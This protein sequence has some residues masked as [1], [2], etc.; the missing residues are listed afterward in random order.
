MNSRHIGPRL[1]LPQAAND[2]ARA[3]YAWHDQHWSDSVFTFVAVDQKRKLFW[4]THQLQTIIDALMIDGQEWLCVFRDSYVV[5][6]DV[7]ADD[8]VVVGR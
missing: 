2:N 7:V 8:E 6:S 5:E 3:L 4:V 1:E